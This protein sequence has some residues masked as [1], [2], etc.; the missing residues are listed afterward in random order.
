MKEKS[1]NIYLLTNETTIEAHKSL[2]NL[3]DKYTTLPYYKIYR[4]LKKEKKYLC[5][6]YT[7]QR[8]VLYL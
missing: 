3:T 4:A 5:N 2:R 7:V 1:K 6:G 8:V